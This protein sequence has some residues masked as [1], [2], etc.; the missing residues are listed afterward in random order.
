[1]KKKGI[2]K[3]LTHFTANEMKI[4]LTCVFLLVKYIEKPQK[5]TYYWF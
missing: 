4:R 5:Y 3:Q 2:L 1:M